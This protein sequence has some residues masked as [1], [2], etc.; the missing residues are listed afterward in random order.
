MFIAVMYGNWMLPEQFSVK[1]KMVIHVLVI[2]I[3][4]IIRKLNKA[5][6][7]HSLKLKYQYN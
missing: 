4:A 7:F 3:W 6:I 1:E 5:I 2:E